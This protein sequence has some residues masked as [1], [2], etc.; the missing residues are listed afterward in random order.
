M[1]LLRTLA[2]KRALGCKLPLLYTTKQAYLLGGSKRLYTEPRRYLETESGGGMKH[3]ETIRLKHAILSPR[4]QEARK[5]AK[6][7]LPDFDM[8]DKVIIVT[9]GARGLGL[10]MAEALYQAGATGMSFVTCLCK[11]KC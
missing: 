6:S 2:T 8:Q 5:A 3:E 9:G 10:T 7:F 11:D 1:H 4:V